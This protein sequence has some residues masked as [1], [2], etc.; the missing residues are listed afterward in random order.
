MNR[1]KHEKNKKQFQ[2]NDKKPG[3]YDIPYD[4]T[5]K[6]F[7]CPTIDCTTSSIDKSNILKH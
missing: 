3:R 6:L 1:N 5:A 4:K 2:D 7:T